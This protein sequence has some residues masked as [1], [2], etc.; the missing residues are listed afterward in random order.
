[1]EVFPGHVPNMISLAACGAIVVVRVRGCGLYA[2]YGQYSPSEVGCCGVFGVK[3]YP[4]LF[5][6]TGSG[7]E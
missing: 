4:F 1:M 3:G 7:D 2:K 6:T 5:P